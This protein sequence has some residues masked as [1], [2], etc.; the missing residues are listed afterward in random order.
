VENFSVRWAVAEKLSGYVRLQMEIRW[1][2]VVRAQVLGK[3]LPDYIHVVDRDN[4]ELAYVKEGYIYRFQRP[5]SESDSVKVVNTPFYEAKGLP[6]DVRKIFEDAVPQPG[7]GTGAARGPIQV[8]EVVPQG[9]GYIEYGKKYAIVIG[10]SDYR[11]LK[12][13]SKEADPT[14][15]RDLDYAD[16]DARDFVGFLHSSGIS[17]GGWTISLLV[18]TDATTDAAYHAIDDVLTSAKQE[19]LVY[20]F[21]SGHARC[22]P[23]DSSDIRLLMYDSRYASTYDGVQY[24]WLR[25]KVENSQAEHIVLFVDA[26]K[27][28]AVGFGRG[29]ADR[30]DARFMGQLSSTQPNK[31]IF[32]S[33]KG[34]QQ[35][36]ESDELKNGVFSHF[37]L[38]GLGGAATDKDN[39]SFVDLGELQDYVEREVKAYTSSHKGMEMQ[40]PT[41]WEQKGLVA[42]DFP[43]AIRK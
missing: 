26:C 11:D 43:L 4:I 42:E 1:D 24:R 16:K 31:V 33:G 23:Y 9:T 39:D 25:D 8:R 2:S 5:P 40:T 14:R 27:S 3:G 35:A 41:L 22:T 18:N 36:F 28:G 13:K 7:L 10:V 38:K 29:V 37:L 17:G 15:L 20:I 21:F 30:P 19:D 6:D 34:T 12:P 32:T